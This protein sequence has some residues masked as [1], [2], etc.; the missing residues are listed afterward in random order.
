MHLRSIDL[1]FE[2]DDRDVLFVENAIDR[3]IAMHSIE[4]KSLRIDFLNVKSLRYTYEYPHRIDLDNSSP[5]LHLPRTCPLQMLINETKV[6]L[7]EYSSFFSC[8]NRTN[9]E[10]QILSIQRE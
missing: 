6:S 8:E 5:P 9:E 7:E 3:E 1:L 10:E 4:R 2:H